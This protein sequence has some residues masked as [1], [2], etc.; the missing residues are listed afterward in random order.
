MLHTRCVKGLSFF[1]PPRDIYYVSYLRIMISF[2]L[3]IMCLQVILFHVDEYYF[4]R[5]RKLSR[6]EIISS[7][8]DGAF[9]IIPLIIATFTRFSEIWK[10]AYIIMSAISC[11]SIVKNEL[12]YPE[13]K[14]KE[15]L[16]HSLLY[17]IHPILLYS[18]YLSW[19]GNFFDAYPNFWI[20]QLLYLALG[21]KTLTY[22]VIYWNYIHE[23]KS[24]LE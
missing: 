22:Q 14:V 13:L 11:L 4:H 23:E 21:F 6:H 5:R 12:F 9:Y 7:L 10:V 17:V 15:K 19:K 1:S 8:T 20:F 2:I 18:F 3:T 24:I 16:T